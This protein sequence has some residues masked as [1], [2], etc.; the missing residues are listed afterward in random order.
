MLAPVKLVRISCTKRVPLFLNSTDAFNPTVVEKRHL[1]YLVGGWRQ[2]GG[3]MAGVAVCVRERQEPQY[4]VRFNQMPLW[5]DRPP[6]SA[7]WSRCMPP[8]I[9]TPEDH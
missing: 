3:R 5:F 4:T 8:Y 6:A 9:F 7:A 1:K 2:E